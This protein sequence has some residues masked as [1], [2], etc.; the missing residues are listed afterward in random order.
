MVHLEARFQ[1]SLLQRRTVQR[2]GMSTQLR[3]AVQSSSGRTT[4][5]FPLHPQH[6]LGPCKVQFTKEDEDKK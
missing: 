3:M 5:R 2:V 4:L 6:Q 1:K